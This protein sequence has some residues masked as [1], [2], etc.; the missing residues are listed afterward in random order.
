MSRAWTDG[1]CNETSGFLFKHDCGFLA[2]NVCAA[3]LKPI[4]DA[5]SCATDGR[6]LCRRCDQLETNAAGTTDRDTYHESDAGTYYSGYGRPDGM[7]WIHT[8]HTDHDSHT[9]DPHDFH[10]GDAESLKHEGDEDFETDMGE[11]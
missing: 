1:I 3:C 5:H 7:V 10:A 2:S 6:I 11:S 8:R 9:Y 4:C